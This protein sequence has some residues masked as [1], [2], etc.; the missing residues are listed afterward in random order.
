MAVTV[1]GVSWTCRRSAASLPAAST[2]PSVALTVA[3][4]LGQSAGLILAKAALNTG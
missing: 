2:S 1:A 4:A 3:A